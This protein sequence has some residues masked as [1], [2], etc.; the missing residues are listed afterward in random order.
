MYDTQV[1]GPMGYFSHFGSEV[2]EFQLN[3]NL[4]ASITLTIRV[5][6]WDP[7]YMNYKKEPPRIV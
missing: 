4:G 3:R 6:F 2:G 1:L 7:V 5:G